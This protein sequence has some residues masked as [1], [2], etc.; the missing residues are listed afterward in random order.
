MDW[1]SGSIDRGAVPWGPMAC[2]PPSTRTNMSAPSVGPRGRAGQRESAGPRGVD[3][4]PRGREAGTCSSSASTRVTVPRFRRRSRP[5]LRPGSGASVPPGRLG[6]S[7]R[8]LTESDR[9][10]FPLTSPPTGRSTPPRSSRS[11]T[12]DHENPS[13]L[14]VGKDEHKSV[15]WIRCSAG[16]G[17]ALEPADRPGARVPVSNGRRCGSPY[18]PAFGHQSRFRVGRVRLRG[19]VHPASLSP[20]RRAMR[21]TGLP[22]AS[23]YYFA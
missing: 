13:V 8:P 16:T 11:P 20:L 18:V 3:P 6:W 21:S 5:P 17:S 10:E 1:I 7:L 14:G 23:Y 15:A 22:R 12:R 9:D 2:S 19:Q 4:K